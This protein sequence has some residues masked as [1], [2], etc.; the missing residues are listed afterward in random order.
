MPG[1]FTTCSLSLCLYP[2][3]SPGKGKGKGNTWAAATSCVRTEQVQVGVAPTASEVEAHTE[4][5]DDDRDCAR[6]GTSIVFMGLRAESST[7][8]VRASASGPYSRQNQSSVRLEQPQFYPNPEWPY[9][10]SP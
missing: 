10:S 6:I 5:A 2:V 8:V 7:S 9:P 3:F 1:V 4:I